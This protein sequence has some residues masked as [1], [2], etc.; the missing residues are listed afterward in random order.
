MVGMSKR[1]V[2][3]GLMVGLGEAEEEVLEVFRELRTARC[4]ALTVGQYMAPS[5]KSIPVKQY[6]HPE[7]FDMYGAYARSM[8]FRYVFSGPFVRSSFNA[9]KIINECTGVTV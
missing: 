2:K 7:T 6:I 5:K 4:D 8:G 9:E 1:I 3:S